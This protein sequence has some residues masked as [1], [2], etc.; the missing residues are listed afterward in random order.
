MR[1]NGRLVL[2][3]FYDNM[4]KFE[5]IVLDHL[6]NFAHSNKYMFLFHVVGK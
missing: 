4:Q 5:S 3:N 2:N 1:Y 6:V